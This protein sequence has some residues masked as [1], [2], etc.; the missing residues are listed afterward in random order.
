MRGVRPYTPAAFR[1]RLDEAAEDPAR[2]RATAE[3]LQAVAD[4][5]AQQGR[6]WNGTRKVFIADVAKALGTKPERIAG[7]LLIANNKGWVELVR[8]DLVGAMDTDKV[9]ASEVESPSGVASYHFV[10]AKS[11]ALRGTVRGTAMKCV[12]VK[13]PLSTFDKRSIRTVTHKSGA[14]V[15]VGCPKGKW[16]PRKQRCRVAM[17]AYETITP[18]R[19]KRGSGGK[20]KR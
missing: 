6:G 16:M 5:L 3:R 7:P 13:A 8:A 20:T 15:L 17:R 11:G 12:K 14:R 9:V 2:F 1:E 4:A 18:G 10:V 19:C